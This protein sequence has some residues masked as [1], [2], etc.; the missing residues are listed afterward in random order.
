MFLPHYWF[1]VLGYACTY[2]DELYDDED[3]NDDNDG[4]V[5]VRAAAS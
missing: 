5:S 3:D 1:I 2:F 4:T